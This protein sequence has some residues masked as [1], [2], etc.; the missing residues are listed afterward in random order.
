LV[1]RAESLIDDDYKELTKGK[2]GSKKARHV[3][4][5]LAKRL[6]VEVV[7]PRV[8]VVKA[9]HAGALTQ[10][11]RIAFW[12]ASLRSLDIMEYVQGIIPPT[13]CF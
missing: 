8:G 1:V 9:L 12:W 2:F 4:T 3:T 10:I 5:W 6:L 11:A 13:D 7:T